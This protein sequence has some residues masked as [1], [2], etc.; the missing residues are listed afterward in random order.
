VALLQTVAQRCSRFQNASRCKLFGSQ[1]QS[2]Q[3]NMSIHLKFL[4][5]KAVLVK[6]LVHGTTYGDTI[7][8]VINGSIV[9]A[10]A[11]SHLHQHYSDLFTLTSQ[12]LL[13]DK[14]SARSNSTLF[15]VRV[16]VLSLAIQ[17]VL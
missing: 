9:V 14:T 6:R 2:V 7:P 12:H 11:Y 15:C 10:M 1:T 3:S 16:P 4:E 17:V 13:R 5:I 8:R